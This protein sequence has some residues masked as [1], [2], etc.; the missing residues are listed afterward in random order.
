MLNL[1]RCSSA[2]NVDSRLVPKS[3]DD[4]LHYFVTDYFDE[5]KVEKLKVEE[6]SLRERMGI[7]QKANT[8]KG[9]S[10]QRYCLYSE[11][12]SEK[13]LWEQNE[14]YPLL[15]IIQIFINPELYQAS[16]E[17]EDLRKKL[18]K[19][20]EKFVAQKEKEDPDLKIRFH[21]YRLLTSGD[22]AVIIRSNRVHA[23]Y[24]ISTAIRSIRASVKFQDQ[25]EHDDVVFYTYSICGVYDVEEARWSRYLSS[26][27]KVVVRL[28]YSRG[29]RKKL[30]QKMP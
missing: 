15:M 11:T 24:D 9:V 29:F 8:K 14:E 13:D 17:V 19:Y 25:V 27:D 1:F 16:I 30:P 28:R 4:S 3:K 26:E 23:A 18:L 20:I 22:F 10:H 7:M 5:I 2:E 12:E 21:L 6:T